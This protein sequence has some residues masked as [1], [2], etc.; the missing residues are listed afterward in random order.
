MI[1][2]ITTEWLRE[3]GYNGPRAYWTPYIQAQ[4]QPKGVVYICYDYT[5]QPPSNEPREPDE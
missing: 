4:T 5:P 2:P 3:H 1:L